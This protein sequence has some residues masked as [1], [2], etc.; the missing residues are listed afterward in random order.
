MTR[1]LLALL[2]VGVAGAA[3]SA[4]TWS[5]FSA[6]TGSA[7]N[8]FSAGT[9]QVTDNDAGAAVLSLSGARPGDAA[10]GCILVSYGGTLDA[11]VRL[12]GSVTGDLAPHLSLTVTRGSDSLPSFSSC[13]S[14][15]ADSTDYIGAGAGVL[16]SGPLSGYPGSWDTGVAD[17][18]SAWTPG[19]SRSYRL[20]VQL[21]NDESAEAK[22]ATATFRWEARNR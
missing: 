17:P 16:Y 3:A 13:G 12:H 2:V 18:D 20:R 6:T 14:F 4:G 15:V 5:A 1:L 10:G 7:G 22:L 8:S 21:A 9:V 19:E 11:D